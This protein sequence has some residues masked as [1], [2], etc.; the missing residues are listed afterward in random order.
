[1]TL[2]IGD[3]APD[4]ILLDQHGDAVSLSALRGRTI[5]LYFYPKAG[6]SMRKKQ[7]RQEAALRA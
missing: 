5:V 6:T 4:F 7:Y 1:M 3:Q 2:A